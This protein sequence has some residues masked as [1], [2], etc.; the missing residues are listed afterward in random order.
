MRPLSNRL[1]AALPTP[2]AALAVLL[3]A[4]C[5]LNSGATTALASPL[6]QSFLIGFNE[7]AS[8]FA[9]VSYQTSD[10]EQTGSAVLYVLELAGDRYVGGTPRGY[11]GMQLDAAGNIISNT[12]DGVAALRAALT[13]PGS[14]LA[15]YG[16]EL[17]NYRPLYLHAPGE[18]AAE[19]PARAKALI[20]DLPGRA[21]GEVMLEIESFDLPGAGLGD[22]LSCRGI[23][24]NV[25]ARGY[26]L[27]LRRDQGAVRL[28]HRD[29]SLPRSRN[30]P[31]HYGIAALVLPFDSPEAT[32]A[33]AVAVIRYS[34]PGFEGLGVGYLALPVPLE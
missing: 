4:L 30:C 5:S 24:G 10:V 31:T 15:R 27:S 26:A 19:A 18:V 8:H 16:I 2:T 33:D 34:F 25:E 7:D 29:R 9:F 23:L 1:R 13:E 20:I 17:G 32:S 14:P 28:I 3:A 12:E 6:T 21:S 22:G 11:G